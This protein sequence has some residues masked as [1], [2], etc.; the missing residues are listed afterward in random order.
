[1]SGEGY[2]GIVAPNLAKRMAQHN[3][4]SR[5]GD[6]IYNLLGWIVGNPMTDWKVDA[7]NALPQATYDFGYYDLEMFQDMERLQCDFNLQHFPKEKFLG[8]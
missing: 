8:S 5:N 7:W 6:V 3:E 1:M 2:A 4:N